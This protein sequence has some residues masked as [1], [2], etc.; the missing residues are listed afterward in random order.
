M[1]FNFMLT[2]IFLA[3]WIGI[4]AF[5]TVSQENMKYSVFGFAFCM[6]GLSG[7]FMGLDFHLFGL[8]HFIIYLGTSVV[9]IFFSSMILPLH[10]SETKKRSF[11]WLPLLGFTTLALILLWGGNH[12]S[13]P[14]GT[15]KAI[16]AFPTIFELIFIQYVVPFF[17]IS[18]LILLG[19]VAVVSWNKF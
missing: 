2:S 11:P 16:I 4:S 1:I 19:I 6:V 5:W 14:N 3:C 7:F 10:K 15:F 8:L 12:F 18:F 17:Y 13:S 9:F